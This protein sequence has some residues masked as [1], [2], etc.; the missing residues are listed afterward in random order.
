MWVDERFKGY[1]DNCHWLMKM[2]DTMYSYI[3][4]TIFEKTKEMFIFNKYVD[5]YLT[6]DTQNKIRQ[7]SSFDHRLIQSSHDTLAAVFRYKYLQGEF[8]KELFEQNNYSVIRDFFAIQ[9]VDTDFLDKTDKE[10]WCYTKKWYDFVLDELKNIS[11]IRALAFAVLIYS[12]RN[13][14]KNSQ[15]AEWNAV[16]VIQQKYYE[17]PWEYKV[18][19]KYYAK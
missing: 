4:S 6:E 17:I 1:V 13:D 16:S 11:L 12:E 8:Q 15:K 3:I 10:Y 9:Y 5:L 19:Y 18:E 14:S 7:I 2:Q